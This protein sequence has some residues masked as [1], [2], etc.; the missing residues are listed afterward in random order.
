[1]K[2]RSKIALNVA[3]TPNTNTNTNTN[4]NIVDIDNNKPYLLSYNYITR[5]NENNNNPST[6]P[7]VILHGL[8]GS[9]RNFN[10]WAK[11]LHSKLNERYDIMV[12]DLRNHGQSVRDVEMDYEL[13]ANDVLFSLESLGISKAHIIGHSMGGKA[14][15]ATALV[16][17][18]NKIESVVILDIS[19]VPYSRED[20]GSVFDTVDFLV[21]SKD[22]IAKATTKQEVIDIVNKEFD[23]PSLRAFLLSNLQSSANPMG[24]FEWKFSIDGIEPSIN[25]IADFPFCNTESCYPG[26]VLVL[27]ASDSTFVRT[28]H[29]ST[30]STMFPSFTMAT[31]R[32][33]GH[34]LHAE[35]PEETTDKVAQFFFFNEK[36]EV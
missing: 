9:G 28:S 12:M 34:W 30:I 36:N 29:V 17:T 19:P 2:S 25:S 7:I 33:A 26:P 10:S 20:I 15:A 35:K 3:T 5:K 27:K 13:M 24:G 1:L 8:L 11:L 16:G 22:K 14:A 4:T 23:D 21:N 32:N 31:Q 6:A 18:W